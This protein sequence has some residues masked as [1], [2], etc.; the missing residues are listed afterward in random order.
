MTH[1]AMKSLKKVS[2]STEV[3][4]ARRTKIAAD[5]YDTEA[6][7][8]AVNPF[9]EGNASINPREVNALSVALAFNYPFN[10]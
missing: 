9:D 3:S 6:M 2:E 8:S 1:A 4:V 10:A 7:R 5:P